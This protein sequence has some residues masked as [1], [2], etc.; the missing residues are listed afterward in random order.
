MALQ[1][2]SLAAG[3]VEFSRFCRASGL[4]AG[5]KESVDA[6]D[7]ARAVGVRDR[8]ILKSVLR[9]V[10]CFSKDEWEKF[11]EL[12]A[13]F[14]SSAERGSGTRP[15]PKR[16]PQTDERLPQSAIARLMGSPNVREVQVDDGKSVLGA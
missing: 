7:A 10:L 15:A 14:W 9:S 13:K 3:I 1:E 12:F 2:E 8:E 16:T 6:L 5:V 4:S 11:D